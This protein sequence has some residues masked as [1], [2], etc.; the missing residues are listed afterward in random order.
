MSLHNTKTCNVDKF[1]KYILARSNIRS[2]LAPKYEDVKF[3]QYRWYTY[4]NTRRSEETMLNQ[5]EKTYSKDHIIILGDWS[6]GKQ[7]KNFISTPNIGLRRKLATRFKVY[8]IDE[9]RTSCL[10]WK[11]EEYNDNLYLPDKT[12][13]IRKMHSILTY[14]MENKRQGCINRDRNSCR[15][16]RKIFEHHMKHGVRPER[17]C[18]GF[19]IKCSNPESVVLPLITA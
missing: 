8:L 7:M 9:Y 18:R 4:M 12:G 6:I 19:E 14:E 3:R 11:T 1:K 5:I 10:N 16:M 2:Q 13:K 17:Y 15:N